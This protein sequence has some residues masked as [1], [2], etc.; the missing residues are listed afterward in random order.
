LNNGFSGK[1]CYYTA[2]NNREATI[3][4]QRIMQCVKKSKIHSSGLGLGS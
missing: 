1:W 3:P 2:L 4:S